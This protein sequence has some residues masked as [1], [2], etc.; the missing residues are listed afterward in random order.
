MEESKAP[1]LWTEALKLAREGIPVFP[2]GHDKRPFTLRGFKDASCDPDIVHAW[3]AHWGVALIGVPTGGK[4]VIV[5]LDLQHQEGWA[6]EK[7]AASWDWG[8]NVLFRPKE[9]LGTASGH[10]KDR[11]FRGRAINNAAR[12]GKDV[13]QDFNFRDVH[14]H[15]S[16]RHSNCSKSF[17]AIYGK[18]GGN[19]R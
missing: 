1:C 17:H 11:E 5:D 16:Q 2:C 8:D 12:G 18:G 15:R 13:R 9:N 7:R 6:A 4:F 19:G 3:W 14:C 10:Q